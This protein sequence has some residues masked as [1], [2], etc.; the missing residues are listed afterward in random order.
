MVV[1]SDAD[2]AL[3]VV[4]VLPC[5]DSI[6]S[7]V[8]SSCG[9]SPTLDLFV[10]GV[11]LL[12]RF[13][14]EEVPVIAPNTATTRMASACAIKHGFDALSSLRAAIFSPTCL[15]IINVTQIKQLNS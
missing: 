12:F 1:L 2:D 13:L 5:D 4:E 6:S 11:V 7:S 10:S 9:E 8:R 3:D 15:S 14:R